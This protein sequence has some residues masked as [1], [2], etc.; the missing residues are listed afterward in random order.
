MGMRGA[1]LTF[2]SFTAAF[3][4]AGENLSTYIT[5][6]R[7]SQK[8]L[9]NV[10]A[11][12]GKQKYTYLHRSNNCSNKW[13]GIMRLRT[14]NGWEQFIEE[15]YGFY[16]RDMIGNN[17]RCEFPRS[18]PSSLSDP[19]VPDKKKVSARLRSDSVHQ[20][21]KKRD[22]E[23]EYASKYSDQLS[24]N[25]QQKKQRTKKFHGQKKTKF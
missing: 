7:L 17:N 11:I 25:Q 16:V 20:H 3:R 6:K 18:G 19:V 1:V 2:I 13:Q 15:E 4:E 14:N 5:W 24:V 21:H 8:K 9:G 10:D 23:K 12:I 22:S